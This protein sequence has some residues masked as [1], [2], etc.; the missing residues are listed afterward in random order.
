MEEL[1]KKFGFFTAVIDKYVDF[2]VGPGFYITCD[3]ERAKKILEDFMTDVNFDSVLRSWCKESLVKGNGFLEIGGSP[4][5]GIE[6]LKILNANYMYVVRDKQGRV[7][8]FNQYKGAFDK[9]TKEKV[10]NFE[11]TQMAHFAFNKVGDCAYGLGIGY[12]SLKLVDN[13]LSQQKDMH[14]LMHRK[15]NA[16]LQAKLGKVEGETKIIP[17]PEDVKAFGQEMETMD[18]KSNWATDALVELKVIDFGNIGEKFAKVVENDLD[19]M[20]YAFQIPGVLLGMANV[21]EG[22]AR[23]QMEAFQRRIQSIQSEMEHIIEEHI[24]KRILNANGLDVKVD[25]EWGVPSVMETQSKLTLMSDLVK[26]FTV[27]PELKSMLEDQLV[28]L[29]DLDKDEWSKLKDAQVERLRLETQP[30]PIVPGQ[31]AGFPQKVQP[32]AEQP[33]Q[34]TPQEM[35]QPLITFM[36][37]SEDKRNKALLELEQKRNELLL[38]QEEK[39]NKILSEQRIQDKEIKVNEEQKVEFVST[40]IEKPKVNKIRQRLTR[41]SLLPA[42]RITRK[43]ES[44]ETTEIKEDRP[45]VKVRRNKINLNYEYD[46]P[47]PHCTEA[48]ED[49]NDVQEWLG[50]DYKKYLGEIQK[51]LSTYEFNQIKAVT[52]IEL[53][54]GYLSNEQVEILRKVLD[55]GF[56]EG[57]GMREM[58]KMVDKKVM[59]K[60]LYRMDNEGNLKLG[61]SGL[62][63]LS[64]SADKRAIGIVRSEVTR[65]ANAGAVEYYKENNIDKVKWIASY[66]DRTCPD[67]EGLNGQIFDINNHPEIP[68]HSMCRCTLAPMVELK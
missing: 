21:A 60:D 66:G 25:F 18:N 3:D 22:L 14:W 36:I 30:Q 59:V 52:E 61:V 5:K 19:M 29:F 43:T 55:K 11:P 2:V 37:E 6:G 28:D 46:K 44:I 63:I 16:P 15:A 27:S 64:K 58:A 34:P 54:A 24:F 20:I 56:A 49:I 31:N 23:V 39:R 32:K 17:K 13:H 10:V 38:E 12:P 45:I 50:F 33:K 41:T 7:L 57:Q 9:F 67:C 42:F 35:I 62:P 8:S 48:F 47:C 40:P 51:V 68:Y 53:Q 26:S 4:K 65:L 1:Y